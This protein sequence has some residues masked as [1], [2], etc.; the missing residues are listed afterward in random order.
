M[1]A[2][3]KPDFIALS[4]EMYKQHADETIRAQ[5]RAREDFEARERATKK[6]IEKLTSENEALSSENEALSSE[7]EALSSEVDILRKIIETNNIEIPKS[8]N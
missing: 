6:H 7:V 4:E 2:K 8:V 3:Q 5:C 1:I